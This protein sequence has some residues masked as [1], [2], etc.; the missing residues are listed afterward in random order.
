MVSSYSHCSQK[1]GKAHCIEMFLLRIEILFKSLGSS[2]ASAFNKTQHGVAWAVRVLV[3]GIIFYNHSSP[4][5]YEFTSNP[6][7]VNLQ[8]IK[9]HYSV[10][11]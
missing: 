5:L 1:T 9:L 4:V 2:A 8:A 10:M 7:A 6:S 3:Y 11:K